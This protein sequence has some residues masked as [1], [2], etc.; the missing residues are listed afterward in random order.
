MR[1]GEEE[2]GGGRTR[3]TSAR[4]RASDIKS[5]NP[6][7]AGGEQSGLALIMKYQAHETYS[8]N[9]GTNIGTN[10]FGVA[11]FRK[12][13]IAS[14]TAERDWIRAH[15]SDHRL[16]GNSLRLELQVPGNQC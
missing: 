8:F 14:S 5:N 15:Q 16:L 13:L 4:G 7:L 9:I 11:N 6:H 10:H 1:S 2:E 3:R 12:S